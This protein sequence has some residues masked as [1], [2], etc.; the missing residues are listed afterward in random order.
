MKTE[1]SNTIND[2]K[3]CVIKIVN[4]VIKNAK[5]LRDLFTVFVRKAKNP[6][7]IHR[8]DVE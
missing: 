1:D 6:N 4:N 7:I 8:A 3:F 5:R 2:V